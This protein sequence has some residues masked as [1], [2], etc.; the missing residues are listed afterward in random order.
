MVT[1]AHYLTQDVFKTVDIIFFKT[2]K[3]M[4]E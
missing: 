3:K 4:G 2:N 1:V